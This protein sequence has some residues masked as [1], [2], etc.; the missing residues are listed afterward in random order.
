MTINTYTT[1]ARA[2]FFTV[3]EPSKHVI[4]AL[5]PVVAV[6]F[7]KGKE[8]YENSNQSYRI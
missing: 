8:F 5:A 7:L 1:G 2:H 4:S 6:N 3:Q